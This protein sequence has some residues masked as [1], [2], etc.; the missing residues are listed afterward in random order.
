MSNGASRTFRKFVGHRACWALKKSNK[1][2]FSSKTNVLSGRRTNLIRNNK[3]SVD[4]KS[5]FNM[6]I[7]C[8]ELVYP[9]IPLWILWPC[10]ADPFWGTQ[11]SQKYF[12][13]STTNVFNGRRSK[14]IRNDKPSVAVKSAFNMKIWCGE[15]VYPE[16]PLSYS[17][18]MLC[19]PI[20]RY[21]K[22]PEKLF[23]FHNKCVQ[24]T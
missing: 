13:F 11:K 15:L 21:P 7:W 1:K 20:L 6:K 16:I 2:V 8:G 4:V 3:P 17:E 23:V 14:L 22:V 24:R 19:G 9:E 5:G 10:C 12:L 18:S